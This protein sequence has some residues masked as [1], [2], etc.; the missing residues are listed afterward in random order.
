MNAARQG[1]GGKMIKTVYEARPPGAPAGQVVN[2][3]DSVEPQM[4]EIKVPPDFVVFQ[5][6][7]GNPRAPVI[8]GGAYNVKGGDEADFG[9]AITGNIDYADND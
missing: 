2:D 7:D 4:G 8:K 6:R 9:I 1:N 3:D 5:S